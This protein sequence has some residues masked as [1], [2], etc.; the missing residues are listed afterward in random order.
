MRYLLLIL[1]L[2]TGSALAAPIYCTGKIENVYITSS[3]DVVIRGKWRNNWTKICNTKNSDT[4][5]C[6][7]WSS[8]VAFA[9]KDDL[10]VT[11]QYIVSD[12]STC[13]TLPTYDSSP[14][15]R[16]IMIR[17]SIN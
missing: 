17:N 7:L 15:P 6:S 14:S 1:I 11:I 8:Y 5:T 9:V 3:G 10:N 16:Y 13:S 4:V 2:G 12:G